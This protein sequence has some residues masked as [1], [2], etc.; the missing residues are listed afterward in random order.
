MSQAVNYPRNGTENSAMNEKS[1]T[2]RFNGDYPT[3]CGQ[4]GLCW[5]RIR[6]GYIFMIHA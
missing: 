6:I 1:N 4:A 5:V 2:R 3:V